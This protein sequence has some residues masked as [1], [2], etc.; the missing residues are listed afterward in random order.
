MSWRLKLT[1]KW[2]DRPGD[3]EA[4][5]PER[6]TWAA[7]RI[8]LGEACLTSSLD[9]DGCRRDTVIG[10]MSGLADWIVENWLYVLW[11]IHPPF[12]KAP[13]AEDGRRPTVPGLQTASTRWQELGNVD[14]NALG[15]WQHRHSLGHGA[16]DIALP[17]IAFLPE[18]RRVGIAVGPAPQALD[19]SIRFSPPGEHGK[20]RL[21]PTW[22]SK[23]DLAT[24]L[25]GFVEQTLRQADRDAA[26]RPWAN[27]LRQRLTEAQTLAA[28][29]DAR[30]KVEFGEL[31]AAR[32]HRL[33]KAL[34]EDTRVLEGILVDSSVVSDERGL[35]QLS[36][37]VADRVREV[38]N[39]AGWRDLALDRA[40]MLQPPHERGYRLAEKARA[41]LRQPDTP[42]PDL[43]GVLHRLGVGLGVF[44]GPPIFRSATMR[45][46]KGGA[47][48]LYTEGDHAYGGV[49]PTRFAIAAGLGRLLAAG[50]SEAA[51][52][53]AHGPQSR[54]VATRQANA[55]A[56]EFL[57][58]MRGMGLTSDV[59]A[60]S[61]RYGISRWAAERH[62]ENRLNGASGRFQP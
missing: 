51:F 40:E 2:L 43:R 4:F 41:W 39:G 42:F 10:G 29:P 6:S 38:G 12:P 11:D 26:A 3:D 13:A 28:T 20:Y 57:L 45:G 46:T 7:L 27:W 9:P 50:L 5:G 48:I 31:V 33:A 22:V 44:D 35:D 52:G 60:L 34:G 61:E 16:S 37:A 17:S 18:D 58:P 32:W 54:W 15:L 59:Q 14:R 62:R 1:V 23:A 8:D 24:D 30:R 19:P 56:A 55:F 49:A 21:A 53:A 36:S 25:G 47:A